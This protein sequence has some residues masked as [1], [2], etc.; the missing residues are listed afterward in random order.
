MSVSVMRVSDLPQPSPHPWPIYSLTSFHDHGHALSA[1]DTEGGQSDRNVSPFHLVKEGDNQP[2]PGASNGMAQGDSAS[3]HIGLFK[4]ELEFP[5][6]GNGLGRK[7][8]IQFN[9]PDIRRASGPFFS[10]PF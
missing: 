7:G 1:T 5:D 10:T 9:E 8:L 2:G 4:V 6:T 3:I